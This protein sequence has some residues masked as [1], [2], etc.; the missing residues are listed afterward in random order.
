MTTAYVPANPALPGQSNPEDLLNIR[1][2]QEVMGLVN[3]YHWNVGYYLVELRRI[4]TQL[5]I[6]L[7]LI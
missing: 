3:F 6:V 4:Q 7:E 5:K 1:A 2:D